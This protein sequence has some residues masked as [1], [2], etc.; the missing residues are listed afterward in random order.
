MRVWATGTLS[1]PQPLGEMEWDWC[2]CES[3]AQGASVNL[4][5]SSQTVDLQRIAHIRLDCQ[6]TRSCAIVPHWSGCVAC[7][8]F[9]QVYACWNVSVIMFKLA[10]HFISVYRNNVCEVLQRSH[11]SHKITTERGDI[12]SGNLLAQ[13]EPH[14]LASIDEVS[15]D[16]RTLSRRHGQSRKG[17]RAAMKGVSV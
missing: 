5:R 17:W 12:R 14:Q 3:R 8:V 11:I 2:I 13:Y 10:N 7:H 16:E 9:A 4:F 6:N 1:D 15:K